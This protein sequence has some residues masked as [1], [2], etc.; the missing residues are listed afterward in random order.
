M[1]QEVLQVLQDALATANSFKAFLQCQKPFML[2]SAFLYVCP[3]RAQY[4]SAGAAGPAS[5]NHTAAAPVSCKRWSTRHACAA[6]D[7]A[8]LAVSSCTAFAA[9]FA[10]AAAAAFRL[11][12]LVT[13]ALLLL[14]VLVCPIV[15]SGKTSRTSWPRSGKRS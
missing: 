1:Q 4:A 3:G 8:L 12:V 2:E 14:R 11:L 9:A 13:A 15:W 6:V 5:N 7:S 10:A